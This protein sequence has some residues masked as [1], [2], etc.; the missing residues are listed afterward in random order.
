MSYYIK[1]STEIV[2]EISYS[3]PEHNAS[4][5]GEITQENAPKMYIKAYVYF[6]NETEPYVETLVEANCEWRPD[7]YTVIYGAKSGAFSFTSEVGRSISHIDIIQTIDFRDYWKSVS[8]SF[9][10]FECSV[11][12]NSVT[13]TPEKTSGHSN[14][15]I[16]KSNDLTNYIKEETYLYGERQVNNLEYNTEY[17]Y[18]IENQGN[19]GDNANI[20]NFTTG[21]PTAL[22]YAKLNGE[23]KNGDLYIKANNN[24]KKITLAAIK[25]NNIYK[26]V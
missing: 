4:Y 22:Y 19:G 12:G 8:A 6:I 17:V 23:Y 21:K 1:S 13:F 14:L 18:T 5:Y 24:Y 7:P 26:S 11:K 20:Y 16:Y 9:N 15:K 25:D 2:N 3:F 10:S